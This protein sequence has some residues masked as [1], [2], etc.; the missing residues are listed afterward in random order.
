MLLVLELALNIINGL[1]WVFAFLCAGEA[2][3]LSFKRAAS[4]PP[5]RHASSE[6]KI[7]AISKSFYLSRLQRDRISESANVNGHNNP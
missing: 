3:S 1:L 6:E 2:T 5:C 4:V 7:Q